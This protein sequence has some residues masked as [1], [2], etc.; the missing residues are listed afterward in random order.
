MASSK[1]NFESLEFI[2]PNLALHPSVSCSYLGYK[3]GFLRSLIEHGYQGFFPASFFVLFEGLVLGFECQACTE[4]EQLFGHFSMPASWDS[5]RNPFF[6]FH[7]FSNLCLPADSKQNKTKPTA[8]HN[9][10]W[11]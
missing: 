3:C 2:F 5:F 11:F 4:A 1:G 6:R 7:F 10:V 8:N 9:K